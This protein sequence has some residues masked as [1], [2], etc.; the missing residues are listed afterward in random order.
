MKGAKPA[1][2]PIPGNERKLD[3]VLKE[4]IESIRPSKEEIARVTAHSNDLMSRLKK[5]APKD[6]E[7][8]AVGS[9]ARGTQI[10]GSSDV[11]IFLLFPKKLSEA[12]MEKKGMAIA[13]KVVSKKKHESFLIK[14]AEHPYVQIISNEVGIKA[15]IVPAFKI[16][17]AEERITAV[18]RSQLHNKFMNEKLSS[19]QKDDV[20]LLKAFLKFHGIQGADAKTEGFSGYLCELLVYQYGSFV[21]VL[22]KALSMKLPIVIDPMHK[23]EDSGGTP[24]VL[25]MTRKFSKNFVVIDATDENRNVAAAVSAE[26][27]ARFAL[28]SRVL[29][30][31]P[32]KDFFFGAKY[33]DAYSERELANIRKTLGLDIYLVHFKVPEVAEDILWQQLRRLMHRLEGDLNKYG[34]GVV[35]ALENIEKNDTIMAFLISESFVKHTLAEGPSAFMGK[36]VDKFL[37]AHKDSLGI[38]FKDDRIMSIEKAKYE[39]PSDLIMAVLDD[40]GNIPSYLGKKKAKLHVNKIPEPLAKLLYAAFIRKTV[41]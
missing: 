18:D 11:D 12:V 24:K 35:M 37:D 29:Y 19:R 4:V 30:E 23:S 8:V 32:S 16:N 7:I 39:K 9:G 41:L 5:A 38:L 33:S 40:T 21:N 36:S 25:S 15:D 2:P 20:R 28:V 1:K 22:K 26:S 31:R 14:Y 10:K 17:K 6:V 27:L 3:A 13:K 34:F